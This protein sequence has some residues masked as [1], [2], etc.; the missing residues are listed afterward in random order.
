MKIQISK[1]WLLIGLFL[2]I[3]CVGTNDEVIEKIEK[4]EMQ[5]SAF[6][7]E[8]DDY[9]NIDVKIDFSNNTST[10]VK[11]YYNPDKKG[12]SYALK[13]QELKEILTLLSISEIKKFKSEYKISHPDFPT[14]TTVIYTNKSKYII[15]DYGLEGDSVLKKLYDIVYKF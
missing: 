5:L 2:L 14:S 7:V 12:S 10:C 8:S 1:Y 4:I 6:G 11:S 3:N 9:P 15:S 13:Q